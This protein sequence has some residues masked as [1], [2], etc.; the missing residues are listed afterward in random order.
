[1]SENALTRRS[2]LAGAAGTATLVGAAGVMGFGAWQ[3]AHAGYAGYDDDAG[4]THAHTLCGGCSSKCGYTAYQKNG[5]LIRQVADTE[6]PSSKGKLCVR[7]FGY[8]DIAYSENRL[9]DPLKRGAD[10][11]FSA[12]SW[13]EAFEEIGEKVKKIVAES[14]PEALALV[15]DP[16]PSGKYYGP[17]FMTAL[18]SSNIYNHGAACYLSR[19]GGFLATLGLKGWASDVARS[20]M[21]MF[22][23]RSYADAMKPSQ[24]QALTKAYK[25]GAKLV[26][27]DP[28]LNNTAT[29]ATEWVPIKPGTDMALVLAMSQQLVLSGNYDKAF[30]KENVEG[31]DAWWDYTRTC[32]P[33][34]AEEICGVPADTITRLAMDFAE[35]APAAS[36]EPSWR[37][38]FGCMY[39]NSGETARTIAIFN[40][41]L[42]CWNHDGGACM[43]PGAAPG[44]LDVEKFPNPPKVERKWYGA[45]EVPLATSSDALLASEGALR[46]DIKGMFFY[47]SNM[48]AGYANPAHLAESLDNLELCVVID[49][50]MSETAQHA[51]YILPEC[52]YL[53]RLEVPEFV[54]G[55][56][57]V[58]SLRDKV[59][60]VIHPNTRPCDEIFKGLADV[61]GVGKY[62][63][64]TVEELAD[65]QL[66][67]VGHSLEEL[68]Q[69]GTI[70]FPEKTF[71]PG[72]TPKWKT[73]S[74]KIMFANPAVEVAGYTAVP[75]WI[76][77]AVEASEGELRLIGGKQIV[78]CHNQ[79]V[80][81][82]TLMDITKQYH[83]E[84]V[85]L[86][87]QVAAERGIADGDEVELSNDTFTGRVRCKVTERMSPWAV[88]IPSHYGCSSPELKEAYGVG[89]RQKDFVPFMIEPGYGGSCDEE[90]CVTVKK[91]GA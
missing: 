91:V 81:V 16:R 76:P 1:M 24:L 8:A 52:S 9:T 61:C 45:E 39:A 13:D 83:L 5:K 40:T 19:E 90:A 11:K 38:A 2:F 72:T 50:Q 86:N 64:F 70:S 89:L 22:I 80:N 18:G 31:F 46:G 84:S 15:H 35:A 58:V 59:L 14:G 41:L 25:N 85:W 34:W 55:R 74:G 12:I 43:Y 71:S 60:E 63:D 56:T 68:R 51:H 44:K 3:E 29:F 7:G 67:S 82:K 33:Q 47:N 26:I 23:G 73:K 65:A 66:K 37:G 42:G 69:M 77:P 20:K 36:I 54:G 10:G 62:F 87:P 78:H 88:F 48:V 79:S 6:H 27:V 30:V 49:V 17:R 4:V 53:E 28:R 32:T 57:P 75:Q 21:T